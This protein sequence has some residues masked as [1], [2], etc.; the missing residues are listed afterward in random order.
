MENANTETKEKPPAKRQQATGKKLPENFVPETV[1]LYPSST[2]KS[3]RGSADNVMTFVVARNATKR[4]IK[5]AVESL[6]SVKVASVRT[7]NSFSAGKKKA[8]VR[9]TADYSAT[10]LASKLGM[11]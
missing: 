9:L 2:E 5:I 1:I 10:D 7:N 3:V 4:T 8:F 11:L 6:Y